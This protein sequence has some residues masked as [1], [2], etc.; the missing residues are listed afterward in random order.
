MSEPMTPPTPIPSATLVIVR[1]GE[2][3]ANGSRLEVLLTE[4]HGNMQVAGGAF[5]FPGGKL[6]AEDD[7]PVPG[8]DF[9]DLPYR[10]GAIREVFEE[11]GVILAGT[12]DQELQD[13]FMADY[14]AACDDA[15]HP[16]A[17]FRALLDQNGL[18]PQVEQLIPFSH[19]ITPVIRPHRFD[20]RFYLAVMPEHQEVR[21]DG[22]EAVSAIWA[23][24][25]QLIEQYG[26]NSAILMFPTR[27]SLGFLMKSNSVRDLLERMQGHRVVP[28]TP[29]IEKRSDGMY[30]HIPAEAGFGGSFFRFQLKESVPGALMLEPV[31]DG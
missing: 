2:E 22:I 14:K 21:Q 23:A 15:E 26:N 18:R 24:P 27:M 19:W 20:A 30:A 6:T 29:Q 1:D 13:R 17:D 16:G 10:L 9:A 3:R 4:R 8:A 5:V 28:I 25:E 31:Q 12:V 11:V 7:R